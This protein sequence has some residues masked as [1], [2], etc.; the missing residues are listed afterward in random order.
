MDRE[1]VKDAQIDTWEL[2]TLR[3]PTTVPLAVVVFSQAIC[4][5]FEELRLEA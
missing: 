4:M 1:L 3:E 2:L 5:R